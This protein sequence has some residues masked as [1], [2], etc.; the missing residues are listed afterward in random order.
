MARAARSRNLRYEICVQPITMRLLPALAC[1]LLAFSTP[2]T[3]AASAPDAT[4]TAGLQTCVTNGIEAGVRQW[5]A[6]RPELGSAM[7]TKVAGEAAKLGAIIDSEVVAAQPI[8]KR[9]TRYYVAL[10]FTRGPLWLVWTGMKARKN[11]FICH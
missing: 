9:V 11:R 3:R 4:L 5:Y 6:D 1:L 2:M 7:T 8:S 10:Y